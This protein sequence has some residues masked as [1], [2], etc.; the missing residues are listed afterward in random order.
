MRLPRDPREASGVTLEVLL[1][2]PAIVPVRLTATDTVRRPA[3]GPARLMATP[4]GT[5]QRPAIGP[6]RLTGAAADIAPLTAVA[7]DLTAVA[8]STVAAAASTVEA[9]AA[10]STEAEAVDLTAAD[11]TNRLLEFCPYRAR[12]SVFVRTGMPRTRVSRESGLRGSPRSSKDLGDDWRCRPRRACL[13]G[14]CPD[15]RRS[16][17]IRIAALFRGYLWFQIGAGP[18]TLRPLAYAAFAKLGIS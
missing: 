12:L 11:A 13:S 16:K 4:A 5:A 3:T 10:A 15:T 6:A 7:E 17:S 2:N 1:R 9:E 14:M 8:A 18:L